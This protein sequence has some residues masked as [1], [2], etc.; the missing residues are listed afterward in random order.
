M[1]GYV[2]LDTDVFSYLWKG[3]QRAEVFRQAVEGAR[4]CISF[5]TVAELHKGAE[6]KGWGPARIGQLERHLQ[7]ILVVPYDVELARTCGRLLAR[8]EADGRRMGEF[9][10]WVAATAL[11]HAIPLVT[12]NRRDFEGIDGLELVDPVPLGE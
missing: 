1:T 7:G 11:R 5:A 6:K 10:A 8:R 2:L 12:N 3:D 4:A 9:D